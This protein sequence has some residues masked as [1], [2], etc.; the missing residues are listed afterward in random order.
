MKGPIKEGLHGINY[1]VDVERNRRKNKK[2]IG[3]ER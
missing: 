3:G 2:G 1:R